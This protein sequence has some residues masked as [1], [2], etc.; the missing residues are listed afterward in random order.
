MP[1][2]RANNDQGCPFPAWLQPQVELNVSVNG[3]KMRRI[4]DQVYLVERR[5]WR[6]QRGA[7]LESK[8]SRPLIVKRYRAERIHDV[9]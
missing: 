4:N 9:F 6:H 2:V 7:S 3:I 1:M 8:R 5:M